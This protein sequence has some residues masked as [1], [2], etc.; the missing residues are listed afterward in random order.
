[1]EIISITC[2]N[3]KKIIVIPLRSQESP[4]A[5]CDLAG[6]DAE[7]LQE[8]CAV[9][10]VVVVGIAEVGLAGPV[11]RQPAREPLGDGASR[12]REE[13]CCLLCCRLIS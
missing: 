5:V 10:E 9:E 13:G 11:P 7:L 1:M 4:G 2:N 6:I 8:R 3:K 12:G